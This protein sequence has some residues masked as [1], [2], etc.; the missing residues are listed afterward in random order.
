MRL[1][2]TC[3][4]VMRAKERDLIYNV[5]LNKQNTLVHSP[6]PF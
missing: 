6:R 5:N 4:L 1:N 3:A 2:T